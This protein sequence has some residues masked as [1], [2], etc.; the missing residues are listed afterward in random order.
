M[1]ALSE[2]FVV[3]PSSLRPSSSS[4]SSHRSSGSSNFERQLETLTAIF[5]AASDKCKFDHPFCSS[6]SDEVRKELDNQLSELEQDKQAYQSALTA[7]TTTPTPPAPSPAQIA[8]E[9]ADMAAKEA[10]LVAQL[11]QLQTERLALEFES[12][13][14]DDQTAALAAFEAQYWVD[15][16]DFQL[17]LNA[18]M[19][20][21]KLLESSIAHQQG[22]LTSLQHTNVYDDAFHVYF[23]GHFGTINGFRLGRL[24]S[25]PVEWSETNA[26]LGQ[27]LL[28]LHTI[29]RL[30]SFSF[31]RYRLHPMGSFSRI[32]KHDDPSTLYELYGSSDS[33]GPKLFWGRRFE[34]ALLGLLFCIR[35]L[36]D[37]A[38]TKEKG[39]FLYK[40]PIKGDMVGDVSVKVQ[41]HGDGKWTKALKYMCIDVKFLLVW[42]TKFVQRENAAA[43]AIT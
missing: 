15:Y 30:T 31:T 24:P 9:E 18:L 10:E 41:F 6:C 13:Q 33:W 17:S 36:G 2:S 4:S 16:Q 21:R 42:C 38:N 28:L 29:A 19:A 8:Q 14:L 25:Q 1:D 20:E 34:T 43:H 7:L 39:G 27:L 22:L 11:Q 37:Y 35:E 26:A 23:D 32:S 12:T 3:L 5:D 40:Y